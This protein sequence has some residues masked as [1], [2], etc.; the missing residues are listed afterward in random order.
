MK[1]LIDLRKWKHPQIQ[2]PWFYSK[3]EEK[4][5]EPGWRFL[6]PLEID[7]VKDIDFSN[8]KTFEKRER[9]EFMVIALCAGGGLVTRKEVEIII[10]DCQTPQ[11]ANQTAQH[12]RVKKDF[13]DKFKL[14]WIKQ[15]EQKYFEDDVLV[16][17]IT[18]Q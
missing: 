17:V 3:L 12:L 1:F 9:M 8:T 11:I 14:F 2:I 5:K 16:L 7:E 4:T 15:D 18:D 6:S 10:P 13:A